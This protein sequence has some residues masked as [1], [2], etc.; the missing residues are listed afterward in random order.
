M[1][2]SHL[3][4]QQK[5]E[6]SI[7]IEELDRRGVDVSK[8]LRF[9]KVRW[10]IDSRGYF[11]KR[12][13]SQYEP[14][15]NQGGFIKSDSYF[16]AFI[17]P[18]GS[19][20]TAAGAQKALIKTA[21]GGDGAVLNP[22]F[23]N[24]KDSTWPEL[25]Q[26]IPWEM[27]VPAQRYRQEHSW[28]PQQPFTLSYLNGRNII[29]KGLKDPDSARGPNI[30]W[31]WYDEGQRDRTGESWKIAIASVR[32][33]NNPQAFVT[34][35]PA[36]KLHW[37]YEFFVEQNLSPLILQALEELGYT[38]DLIDWYHGTREDNKE[39]LDKMYVVSLMAGYADDSYLYKQEVEG[40][41]VTPEGSI[42]DRRWFDNKV[43]KEI[44]ET[45]TNGDEEED[46]VIED[47]VRYW[48]LAATEKKIK[49]KRGKKQPDET[50]GTLMSWD[51]EDFYIEHQEGGRWLWEDILD[52]IY[53]TALKD[54]PF[55]KIFVEEEPGAGG[56]NQ[57]AAIQKFFREGDSTHKPLPHFKIEGHRPEGDKVMRANIWFAEASK[58]NV[59]LIEGDWNEMFLDQVDVFADG[60]YDDRVD[61]A[62]GARLNVAP[63]ISWASVP[64][65]KL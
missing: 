2:S 31:L 29:C 10:P 6:L 18:R 35:T 25:R 1:D 44:P 3:T 52:V 38:K 48:D 20:K 53:R 28:K 36:G 17:G 11:T 40:L 50:V 54:G 5:Q 34:A 13:G 46:V 26:W 63:I 45:R 41:F 16:S 32:V 4:Q 30:N 19:G 42:G 7:L 33:G 65:M 22:D 39:H 9:K 37:M 12:D 24:F 60:E 62:S 27:V 15:E 51:G 21:Q 23:T 8:A 47:R 49:V 61:S 58:G 56:K 57:I 59:Y 14:S 43:L 64:F 55:V